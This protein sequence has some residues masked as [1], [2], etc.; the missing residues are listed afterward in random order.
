MQVLYAFLAATAA[1]LVIGFAVFSL[2][3]LLSKL[4][5]VLVTA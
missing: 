5:S 1:H 4:S 3:H 2:T